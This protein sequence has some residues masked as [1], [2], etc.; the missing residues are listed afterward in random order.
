MASFLLYLSWDK[1]NNLPIGVR[2]NTWQTIKNFGGHL[3]AQN[4]YGQAFATLNKAQQ[5]GLQFALKEEY[6]NNGYNLTSKQLVVSEIRAKAIAITADYYQ[7]LFGDDPEFIETR[8]NFAMKNNTLPSQLRREEMTQFFFWTAWAAATNRPDSDVTYTNN[9]PHEPLIDN[10]PTAENLIWSLVSIILLVAG[11]GGLVWGWAFLR[12][13][14]EDEPKAPAQDPLSL[15]NLTPSQKALG[16]YLFVVVALFTLQVFLGGF[17]AHYTV[18][19][20]GFYGIDTS[21]WLPYSVV[22]TWHL[23][24]AMFWIATAFLAAGLFLAPIINGGK[25]P[26]FQKLGVDLLFWALVIVTAGTFIG[27]WL[28]I[29]HLLPQNLSFWFGHQGYEYLDLGR[30]WQLLKFVGIL[31]WLI[32]M[33]RGL[34]PALKGEG[35]KNLLALFTASVVAV[36]LFYGA[37]FF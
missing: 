21:K 16:K 27:N 4:K 6:R 37:G 1:Y 23:Q 2:S 34:S 10:R 7:R 33:L 9:W 14:D 26:R 15:V 30:F 36:G 11:I 5:N 32:L 24:A 3:S 35:D 28:A 31:F 19:G 17:T 18:E 22:R 13:K 20:Q 29:M 12:N 25:D 8:G